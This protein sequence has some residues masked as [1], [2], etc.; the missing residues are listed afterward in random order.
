M[1]NVQK[2][3]LDRLVVYEVDDVLLRSSGCHDLLGERIPQRGHS[4][5]AVS[6]EKGLDHLL[7]GLL[8]SQTDHQHLHSLHRPLRL[9][10]AATHGVGL[11]VILDSAPAGT[12]PGGDDAHPQHCHH[13]HRHDHPEHKLSG[14]YFRRSNTRKVFPNLSGDTV[15]T[16]CPSARCC[17]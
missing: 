14:N 16:S 1:I 12:V 9:S 7:L 6:G 3:D 13:A 5:A 2:N 11:G 8:T 10:H 15:P 17:R 4:A